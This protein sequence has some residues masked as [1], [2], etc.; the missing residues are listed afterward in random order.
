MKGRSPDGFLIEGWREFKGAFYQGVNVLL[1]RLMEKLKEI[2]VEW[3][4]W[5]DWR[6]NIVT[7]PIYWVP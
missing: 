5:V 2:D 1:G 7:R 3:W 6:F 4:S